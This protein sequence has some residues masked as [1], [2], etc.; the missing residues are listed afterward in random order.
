[1]IQM[2]K[3]HGLSIVETALTLTLLSLLSIT[4]I[5]SAKSYYLAGKSKALRREIEFQI[6]HQLTLAQITGQIRS[7]HF[8]IEKQTLK[9]DGKTILQFNGQL[10]SAR[11]GNVLTDKANMLS[12][13]PNHSCTPGTIVLS[14]R[15]CLIIVSK[16]GAVRSSC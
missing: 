5:S 14:F 15:K 6:Q 7:M 16:K 13:F 1:M 10:N 4:G 12:V 8:D 11:F 3:Q 2:Q 9:I